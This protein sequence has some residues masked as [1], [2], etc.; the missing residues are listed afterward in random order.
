MAGE[1]KGKV[2]TKGSKQIIEENVGTIKFYRNMSLGACVTY[3][4][5]AS[6]YVQWTGTVI[7]MTVLTILAHGLANQFMAMMS[8]PKLSETGA[9]L[10]AGSDLNM[11]GGIAEHVKD[12]IILTAGTQLMSLMSNYFWFLLILGPLRAVYMLWGSVIQPWLAQKQSQEKPQVD[13]KKQ[14]KM[15]RK[16]KRVNSR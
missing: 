13:E 5:V 12:I 15:E 2:G 10:D 3:V 14:K 16:M 1:K 6:M 11:E 4:C 7:T 9:I 8:R